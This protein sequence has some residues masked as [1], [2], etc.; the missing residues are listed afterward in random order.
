MQACQQW[1]E[2][3]IGGNFGAIRIA[4]GGNISRAPCWCV[5]RL[6]RRGLTFD[7]SCSPRLAVGCQLEGN[8][9]GL[10]TFGQRRRSAKIGGVRSHQSAA[11]ERVSPIE[12]VSLP[13]KNV[14]HS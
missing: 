12:K 11:N 1:Q 10:P 2:I 5:H 9:K 13:P 7:L 14:L 3:A 6:A 4:I 8:A